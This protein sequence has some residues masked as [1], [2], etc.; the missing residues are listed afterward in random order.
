MGILPSRQASH[1]PYQAVRV[2]KAAQPGPALHLRCAMT[3]PTSITFKADTYASFIRQRKLDIVTNTKWS[4]PPP[5]RVQRSDMRPSFRGC[6]DQ[7][8]AHKACGR[9]HLRRDCCFI[10]HGTCA[11]GGWNVSTS[12]CCDLRIGTLRIRS[13]HLKL[14]R[15]A[16]EATDHF[17]LPFAILGDCNCNPLS[18]LQDEAV[19]RHLVDL[20]RIHLD[21]KQS[22][23]VLAKVLHGQTTQ[24]SVLMPPDGYVTLQ[25]CPLGILMHIKQWSL[26]WQCL[27]RTCILSTCRS[28]GTWMGLN[29][30]HTYLPV[31]T[32][33]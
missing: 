28:L 31:E 19:D 1:N 27:H 5:D 17:N 3:N 30:D 25:C 14:L 21:T 13:I 2:G 9:Y 12:I 6:H 23:R 26:T 18:L 20:K 32:F 8:V 33:S 11:V 10:S 4:T 16:L 7:P 24:S 15:H 22:C 29:L